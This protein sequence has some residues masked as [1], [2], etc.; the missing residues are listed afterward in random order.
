[1]ASRYDLRYSLFPINESNFQYC[2]GPGG[3]P[4]PAAPGSIQR[5][6]VFGLL[7]GLR[8]YLALKTA[9]ERL[10]WSKLSNVIA[11]AQPAVGV[12]E[13]G[14]PLMFAAPIPNPAR[15]STGFAFSLPQRARIRVDVFDVQGRLVQ[16]VANTER[17]PGPGVF[18]WDLH[19]FQGRPVAAGV[20]LARAEIGSEMFMHRILVVR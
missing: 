10:N 1:M 15:S 17:D 19:D 14:F 13:S 11:F 8:Y 5:F 7:P 6:T 12:Q 18:E 4:R 3:L 2:S 9:D 16:R 20:Y